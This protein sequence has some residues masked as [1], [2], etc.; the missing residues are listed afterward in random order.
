MSK[1]YIPVR[2]SER[3]E[4]NTILRESLSK[5]PVS[6]EDAAEII[7]GDRKFIA[8]CEKN[9]NEHRGNKAKIYWSY[10]KLVNGQLVP[11][12]RIFK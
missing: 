8:K 11:S 12:S 5:E 2:I 6:K 3:D 7:S 10:D 4:G 1:L 9:S